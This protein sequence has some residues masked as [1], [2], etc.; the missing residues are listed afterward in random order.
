MPTITAANSVFM[1][2]VVSLFPTPVQL[3]GFS[4]DDMWDTEAID[5]AETMMGV[6]GYLSA[7]WV[8]VPR[9]QTIT[10]Q[11]DSPSNDFFDSWAGAQE[12]NRELMV[13]NG[14]VRL[15]ALSKSYALV[16]GFLTQYKPMAQ[17]QKTLRPRPYR[18]TWNSI[19]AAPI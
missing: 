18:I 13:A 2:T 5:N 14:I 1:L 19:T 3:Q 10:L 4:A 9:V 11:A 8:A 15:P 6:D 12:T 17:L 7:G 16:R